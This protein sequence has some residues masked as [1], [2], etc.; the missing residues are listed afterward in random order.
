MVQH[1]ARRY[2]QILK[3]ALVKR[4]LFGSIA[5]LILSFFMDVKVL[6]FFIL[7]IVFNTYLYAFQLGR[8]LPTDLELSTFSTVLITTTYGIKWGLI[9]AV[10]TKLIAC[11]YSGSV[12][13]DHMFM[14]L[15]YLNAA[16]LAMVFSFVNTTTLGLII[17]VINC[18]IM[19]FISK[20]MLSLDFSINLCYTGT[21]LVFNFIVFLVLTEP[22]KLILTMR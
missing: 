13:V 4:V 19:Y 3:G 11:I 8:G 7:A 1:S 5:I 21:N 12:L 17:V 9:T 14:I 15:T 10:L 2:S 22:V 20:Y 6:I 18:I 16:V